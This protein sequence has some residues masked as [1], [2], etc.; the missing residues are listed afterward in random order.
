MGRKSTDKK[1]N[2]NELKREKYL[3]LLTQT[4]KV[5][6]LRKYT[7][8]S[9]AKELN[10]TKAT[11]Y[12]YF[13]SK[14][15]MVEIILERV[16]FQ[17]RDFEKIAQNQNLSFEERYY[18]IIELFAGVISDISNIFLEDLRN[19]YPKLWKDVH[20][21][22][23]Y[24]SEVLFVFYDSGKKAG[25]FKDIN[26]AVLAMTDRMFFNAVSDVEFLNKNKLTLK[27][28]FEEYYKV[29]CFGFIH[30]GKS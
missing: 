19:D 20:N 21:F 3:N 24:T 2:T 10:I 29:K 7:M 27:Q 18:Q 14:D 17:L 26:S 11:L 1:R 4:F 12:Q 30:A 5:H 9:I 28:A 22:I 6:G 15:E 16:I 25:V 23:E 13:K 8:D